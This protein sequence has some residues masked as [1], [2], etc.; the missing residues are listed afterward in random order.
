MPKAKKN[1]NAFL[2]AGHEIEAGQRKRIDLVL[3]TLYNHQEIHLPLEVIHGKKE[4]PVLLVSACVHGDEINGV[5]IISRLLARKQLRNIHGTLIIAP[6]VNVYG[7]LN[8]SRYLPD[9]RDLNRSFPG[10]EKGSMAGRLAHLF[11]NEILSVCTHGIDLHTGAIHRS[12]L[13]QIRVDLDQEGILEIAQAFQV[14]VILDNPT[15]QNSLRYTAQQM[16][17]PLLLYEAGE[18]LRFDENAIRA[19]VK[20]VLGVMRHLN[21]LPKPATVRAEHSKHKPLKTPVISRSSYWLRSPQGGILRT[22]AQLGQFV[23]KGEVIGH[24]ADPFG[25]RAEPIT[26]R[27]AGIIIGISYLP[28]V[29]EGTAL[30]HIAQFAEDNVVE[31]MIERFHEQLEQLEQGIM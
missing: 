28:L 20:G 14:P 16:G 4:G 2:I 7:F 8:H 19:G 29:E 22:Q 25:Q 18:A 1:R 30:F 26:T 3:G 13:P 5:E 12:N 9:R 31:A 15:I 21:M 6:I 17:I 27:T 23:A 10:S 24:V 11:A